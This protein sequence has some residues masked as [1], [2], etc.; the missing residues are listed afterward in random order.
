M[1]FVPAPDEHTH[2][3]RALNTVHEY[4]FELVPW[5]SEAKSRDGP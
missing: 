1:R 2:R 4:S 3:E 5:Y